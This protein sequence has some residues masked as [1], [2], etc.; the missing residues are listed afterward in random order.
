MSNDLSR[1]S[2]LT[3]AVAVAGI[4][5]LPI[6]VSASAPATPV[7]DAPKGRLRIGI[8]GCGGKGW[9]GMELAAEHGDIVA[10]ADVDS[11]YR[12]KAMIEHPK[13]AT[14]DDYRLMFES[15]RGHMDAVIISTP[16]HHH[17]TAA[18]L[19]MKQKLHTYCEKP[20]C[21]TIWECRQLAKLARDNK[22]ATQ[23]GNQ[24]TA[25]T[26]MRKAAALIQRG[27]FGAVKE[28]HLWTDR[29]ERYW[30][31]GIPRP[32]AA[33]TPKKLN[34]DL[35][36]G[37]RPD[38]PFGEGYHPFHW[39]GFWDFGT[40]ALGDMGCHIFNMAFMAL[41][42]RD[43]IAVQAV[44]SGHNRESFPSWAHVT[45]E[46]PERKTRPA[47]KLHWYDGGK[48]PPASLVPGHEMGGNGVIVVCEKGTIYGLDESNQNFI[49]VGGAA[50]PDI[51]VEESPGH[52]AEFAR[53]AMGGKPA[54]SN[55]PNYSGPLTETV[56]LGNLA[57]WA[58]GPRLE[59][60][61][62]RMKVKGTDEYDALIKP[63]FR[64]G[65]GV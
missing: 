52:M 54:V 60:D 37:P 59:W 7:A 12:A 46:F 58:N 51:E 29:A 55:F 20:L 62:K 25:S 13:A 47:L 40:G 50:L 6:E 36:V 17:A 2:V 10:I 4:A 32:A 26:P 27:D 1:R 28:I 45:Y 65:Y 42:L 18:A 16:D 31:Q 3:G 30:K 9:T 61:A 35:W 53:A 56:L 23:M 5:A 43:P 22:V 34:F 57:I 33:R 44:T 64:Q 41:D 15:M 63:T 39:R 8:V 48:K 21:R 38:R 49:M 24:S 19:A 14:F 11:E